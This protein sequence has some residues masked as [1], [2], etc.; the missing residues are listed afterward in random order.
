MAAD[1][2]QQMIF[3]GLSRALALTPLSAAQRDLIKT[4]VYRRAGFLFRRS[5]NFHHWQRAH[6]AGERRVRWTRIKAPPLESWNLLATA[7]ELG[8]ESGAPYVI[9]PV[10]R[11]EAVTLACLHAVRQTA[12]RARLVVV[13]DASPERGLRRALETLAADGHFTLLQNRVNRGY[14]ASVERGLSFDPSADVVLLNSDVLVFGHWFDR[15]RAAVGRSPGIGTVTPLS[16]HGDLASYPFMQAEQT[17]ALE[18]DLAELDA[19]ASRVN[20]GRIVDVP[21]GVGFCLYVRRDCLEAVGGFDPAFASGYGEETDLCLRIEQAGWRNVVATDVLVRHEG[22]LSF[23]SRGI[24][25]RAQAACR[26]HARHPDFESRVESFVRGDPLRAARMRIDAARLRASAGLDGNERPSV[27]FV[28]HDWDGGI[29]GHIE[30]LARSLHEDGVAVWVLRMGFRE[31]ARWMRLAASPA[32][33][34]LEDL[35]CLD[36]LVENDDDLLIDLLRMLR[37]A[38]IHLHSTGEA[39]ITGAEFVSQLARQLKVPLDVTL[40]DYAPLC[41]R[42]HLEGEGGRY[43]GEPELADCQ[44]CV[45]ER[46]T[47]FGPVDMADWRSRWRS[48]LSQADRVLCPTTD[49]RDR[50][51]RYWPDA[52]CVVSPPPEPAAP[53]ARADWSG[54]VDDSVPIR[55]LVPGAINDQKGFRVLCAAAR[56]AR[57]R[58]LALE[59]VVVGYTI[60]DLAAQRAGIRVTG[61]YARPDADAVLAQERRGPSLAWLPSIAPETWGATLSSAWRVGL[62]PVVFDLGAYAERVRERGSGTVLP[63]ALADSPADMNEAL[64]SLREHARWTSPENPAMD[65]S[66]QTKHDWKA[67]PGLLSPRPTRSPVFLDRDGVLN[68]ETPAF[69]RSLAD[70]RPIPESLDAV[71]RLSRADHPV[72][73]ITNQSGVGRGLLDRA[74]LDAIH[75]RL[76]AQ[77]EAAGGRVDAIYDCPHTPED[78]CPCRKPRAGLLERAAREGGFALAGVP[79]VGDRWTDV[80]AARAVGARPILVGEGAGSASGSV[81]DGVER[82]PDLAAFVDRYL[83]E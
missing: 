48:V 59:F 72:I 35:G 13:E 58:R 27:L 56:D 52:A 6:P 79:F 82:Y 81:G 77:V 20:A 65:Q 39:G 66:P 36:A 1:A 3:R 75:D 47:R 10:Y 31:N 54:R 7:S 51:Q 53:A 83:S 42:I 38:Q 28:N 8:A 2:L 14:L 45:E 15:L 76:R 63:L 69:V 43:C 41:P 11:N 33:T 78:G 64:L 74:T 16:N 12:P 57:Q 68:L 23:G 19:W 73:V 67:Y 60:D 34:P 17:A 9:V 55:I 5:A 18:M 40:H 50:V 61:P 70:W 46:G 44:T 49:V 32:S 62:H 25:L 24:R 4:L 30:T 71:A 37:V 29:E 22:G 80:E 21:T 26:L